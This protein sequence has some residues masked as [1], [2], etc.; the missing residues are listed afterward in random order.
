MEKDPAPVPNLRGFLPVPDHPGQGEGGP[1][2]I[3]QAVLQSRGP[4]PDLPGLAGASQVVIKDGVAQGISLPVQGKDGPGGAAEAD[5]G[6]FLRAGQLFDTVPD[7]L[8][9]GLPPVPGGLLIAVGALAGG[10]KVEDRVGVGAFRRR[11]P[12]GGDNGGPDPLGSGIDP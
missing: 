2:P 12:L 7:H 5:G 4:F 10:G 6:D 3:A 1:H 9:K 11:L 8:A